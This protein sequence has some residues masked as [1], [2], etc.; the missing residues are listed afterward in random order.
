MIDESIQFWQWWQEHLHAYPKNLL[1]EGL[2]DASE[3]ETATEQC[4]RVHPL[5]IRPV[6]R[7]S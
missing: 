7:E 4:V 1:I 5:A 3:A 6:L 2:N